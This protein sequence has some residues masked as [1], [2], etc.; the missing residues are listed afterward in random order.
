M[1]KARK[2]NKNK[3]TGIII[4]ILLLAVGF[5]AVST[6]LYIN[7][8]AKI[9]P[10][11]SNFEENVVFLDGEDSSVTYPYMET[12]GG[13]GSTD[14]EVSADGKTLTFTTQVLKNI[15]DSATVY[16]KIH[17]GSQYDARL[18]VNTAAEGET[19]N[20]KAINC[21]QVTE[22]GSKDSAAVTPTTDNDHISITESSTLDNTTVAKGGNS[23]VGSVVVA[24]I[25]SYVGDNNDEGKDYQ[26]IK[27]QCEIN[28]T[29]LEANN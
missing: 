12:N 27:I 15:G 8:T 28:A 2:N 29:A 14:V 13:T 7:G 4:A 1:K 3:K 23:E 5:A 9:V 22:Y 10:D 20:Y 17:N 21:H 26:T 16:F 18:G 25:K 24:M 19:A 6:T 11:D